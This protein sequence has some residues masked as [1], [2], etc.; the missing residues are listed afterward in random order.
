[1]YKDLNHLSDAEIETLMQRY[2]SGEAVLL[3]F[4]TTFLLRL[5]VLSHEKRHLCLLTKVT[6][7]NDIR[8]AYEGTDIISY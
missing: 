5:V 2:Y 1:M 8:F 4:L 3:V 7:F 6:F